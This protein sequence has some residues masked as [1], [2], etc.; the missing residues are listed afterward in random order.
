MEI[1]SA[2]VTYESMNSGCTSGYNNDCW[3]NDVACQTSSEE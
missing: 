2:A 3:C 1:I